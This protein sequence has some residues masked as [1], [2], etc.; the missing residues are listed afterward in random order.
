MS[1]LYGWSN[2]WRIGSDGVSLDAPFAIILT[3]QDEKRMSAINIC[4]EL[5]ILM[6]IINKKM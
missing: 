3:N 4:K 6:D 1:N 2:L 5:H